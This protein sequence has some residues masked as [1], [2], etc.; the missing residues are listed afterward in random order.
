MTVRADRHGLFQDVPSAISTYG[1]GR[2]DPVNPDPGDIRLE[3]IARSL[4]QQCRWTGHT[5]SFYSVAEHCVLASWIHPTLQCLL[6]DASEAYLSDLARPIKRS[7]VLGDSYM[8]ME[9]GL[10]KAIAARF[11][12]DHPWDAGVRRADEQML[13]ME[14][15]ALMIG[16]SQERRQFM[17]EPPTGTPHVQCWSPI[18]A[19]RQFLDRF[20]ELDTGKAVA[21]VVKRRLWG[22][23]LP[24][25]E[26]A[27]DDP[28]QPHRNWCAKISGYPDNCNCRP[29]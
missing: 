17:V 2:L 11:G 19:E 10:E 22:W 27:W 9:A 24:I 26:G 25:A 5:S 18:E 12:L 28:Q 23:N 6:H 1:G 8:L 21:P 15:H 14:W 7:T 16:D 20:S 29:S 4:S 3:S 13:R